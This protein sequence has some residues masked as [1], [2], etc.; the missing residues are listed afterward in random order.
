MMDAS[1]IQAQTAEVYGVDEPQGASVAVLNL[2][3][4]IPGGAQPGPTEVCVAAIIL[5][6]LAFVYAVRR[7]FRPV[8]NT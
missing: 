3:A 1:D 7:G 8:L 6:S 5:G 2:G 4:L